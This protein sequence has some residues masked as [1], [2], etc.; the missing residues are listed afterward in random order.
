MGGEGRRQGKELISD[1]GGRAF[2]GSV[3]SS[4]IGPQ[5]RDEMGRV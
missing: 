5:L 1:R 2:L 3:A 4:G